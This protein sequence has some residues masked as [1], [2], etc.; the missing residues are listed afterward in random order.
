LWVGPL[1][2]QPTASYT[3]T[4]QPYGWYTGQQPVRLCLYLYDG[5]YQLLAFADWAPTT[6]TPTPTP[7]PSPIPVSG[8]PSACSEFDYQEDAQDFFDGDPEHNAALDTDGDGIA[9]ESLPHRPSTRPP[10][11]TLGQAQRSTRTALR[12]HYGGRFMARS[13]YSARCSRVSRIRFRCRVAWRHD[14]RYHGTVTL[15]TSRDDDGQALVNW[16]VRVRYERTTRPTPAPSPVPSPKPPS[17]DC[18]P[19]YP[20]VC[21]PS[22]P[23]DLD[24]PDIS[25][26]DFVVRGSDPHGFD[27]DNDGIGCES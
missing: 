20:T 10:T 4:Q 7:S 13:A 15:W 2:E 22:P 14:G 26:R 12:R 24:C 11:L 3:Q 17:R 19:S 23:P 27:G 21:I 6:P 25:A 5:S 16:R 9:C 18:D 8:T 1:T